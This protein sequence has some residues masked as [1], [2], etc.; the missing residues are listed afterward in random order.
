VRVVRALQSALL[1]I[2]QASTQLTDARA[3]AICT[4]AL[5]AAERNRYSP[6][7][8]QLGRRLSAS[9]LQ[10]GGWGDE[11]W[12]TV[13]AVRALLD[14]GCSTADPIIRRAMTFVKSTRDP[15]NGTWYDEPF[16]TML[17][18][19]LLT[20][21]D[22][23]ENAAWIERGLE[24]IASLQNAGG[25]LIGTRYTGMAISLFIRAGDAYADKRVVASAIAA[26]RRV[27]ETGQMWSAAS[28]SNY[29]ALNALLDAGFDIDDPV[30]SA[31]TDWFIDNQDSSGA[32]TQVS[33][34]H[35]T[36]MA[37]LVLS[38]LLQVPLVHLSPAQV[39]VMRV[40]RESGGLRVDFQGSAH[41]TLIPSERMKLSDAVRD[42]LARRQ[43]KVL[44]IIG[45]TRG[46]GGDRVHD[47]VADA[48]RELRRIGQY[49]YGHLIPGSIQ[50]L[51]HSE[52]ADHIR[53]D[54]DER[55]IDLPWELVHDGQEFLCLRFAAGRR[56]IS[57][58]APQSFRRRAKAA[59]DMSA[60]VVA[61]PTSDL[62]AAEREGE[63]VAYLLKNECGVR[64]D[65]FRRDELTKEDFL[66]SLR[67]YDIV[68]FAGHARRD[69]DNPD[70]S[71]LLFCDGEV[72]AFEIARFLQQPNVSVVF[73]NACWSAQ[74]GHFWDS[75]SPVMRGLGRTFI[76][77]GVGAFIGYLVPIPDDSA[78][79][80]AI[81]VYSSLAAGRSIGESVRRARVRGREADVADLTWASAVLYGDPAVRV[82]EPRT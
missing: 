59:R 54:V 5:V 79:Q 3:I 77:S 29:Y 35:D 25:L 36:A 31:A 68:H 6:L 63:K 14:T 51:L 46:L 74:E 71:C 34:I 32:W 82:F 10:S 9:Q 7:V 28:W 69:G 49:T 8:Q 23:H 19:D 81:E 37:V 61:N 27:V 44:H 55:V 41:G 80:F 33:S 43:E 12:D 72:Q 78:T 47:T 75:Y 57:D 70:E 21:T 16:E 1:W 64:V 2:K 58:Q 60:L 66:L 11:L 42:D 67:E 24:W 4:S 50:G 52:P 17:V 38:R 76:Y 26:L 45:R 22:R 15:L 48:E 40:S 62:P 30:V 13:W 18:L 20:Q 73:L 56:L 39:A 53:L 65:F